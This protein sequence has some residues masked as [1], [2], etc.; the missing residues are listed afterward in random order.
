MSNLV[1][2][3]LPV[4]LFSKKHILLFSLLF[5]IT[6]NALTQKIIYS[7]EE[8][9]FSIV[10]QRIE[11]LAENLG[12]ENPDFNALF[13]RLIYLLDHPLNLNTASK[14]ELDD[15]MLLND[16]QINQLLKHIEK[17]GK[18]ISIYEIQ[19]LPTW[20]ITTIQQVLPFIYVSDRFTDP[21]LTFSQLMKSSSNELYLRWAKISEKQQGYVADANG[22]KAYLGSNDRLYSRYRFKSANNVS[23]GLTGSK[24]PGEEFFK[25]SQKNGFDFYSGHFYLNNIG[26]IKHL[27]VGDYQTSFGQG[28]T[29]GMGPA[30]GKTANVLGIKRPGYQFKP[31]TSV[32]ESQFL[33]GFATTLNF[34]PLELSLFYSNK[35][36]DANITTNGDTTQAADDGNV[37]SSLQTSGLH[38]T[39][40]LLAD[41]KVFGEQIL[42]GDITYRKRAFDIGIVGYAVN[43]KGALQQTF[44]Y[45][46]QFDFNGAR[47]SVTGLHYSAVLRNINFFGENSISLNKGIGT[48]NGMILSVD[49]KLGL[50][51]AHR[52]YQ[53]QFQNIYSNAFGE[54]STPSNESGFYMGAEMKPNTKWMINAYADLFSSSWLRYNVNGPSAGNEVL[55]QVAWKPNKQTEIY[56]RIRQRNKQYNTTATVNDVKNLV[57]RTQTNYRINISHK[58]NA[59]WSLH[60]RFEEVV[61]QNENQPTQFGFLLF[62]DIIYQPHMSPFS[63]NVRYAIFNTDNFD[64]RI[65]A[66]ENDILYYYSIPSYYYRGSRIYFNI[67]YQYKKWFDAWIKVGQWLYDNKTTVGSGNDLINANHKTD[68]RLQLRFSF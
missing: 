26:I 51:F 68:I 6:Q 23:I 15:L 46:N 27:V 65:Y 24:D 7:S 34:K 1:K 22:N 36:L 9:K 54:G 12:D 58:M 57:T 43:Y 35:K 62:Q 11:W 60:S 20:D 44:Q 53:K 16:V 21:H 39:P 40:S 4:I 19:S 32:N 66:Y 56:F 63:F 45:Y 10:D 13:D 67:R 31:F 28:L 42:G 47:N 25:G 52:Y 5:C 14:D 55:A 48:I 29:I 18:L 61:I 50:V 64:T 49:P 17:N 30:F 33:R 2:R 41:K 37:V 8:E 3:V 38:N 59:A